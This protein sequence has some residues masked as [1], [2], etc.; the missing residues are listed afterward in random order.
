MD[1]ENI[2]SGIEVYLLDASESIL[3]NLSEGDYTFT[4]KE[5]LSGAG[6]LFVQT[7]AKS[8]SNTEIESGDDINVYQSANKE[9]TI[10]GI[11]ETYELNVYTLDGKVVLSTEVSTANNVVATNLSTG[12]YI[13]QL[14]KDG[15]IYNQKIVLE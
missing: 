14:N 13:V 12:V 3:A 2:P 7:S 11:T 4:A 6:N 8:L 1:S 15:K 9:I 5:D 10:A